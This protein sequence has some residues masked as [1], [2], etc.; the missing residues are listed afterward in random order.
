MLEAGG[1]RHVDHVRIGQHDE[2]ILTRADKS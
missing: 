2:F 1:V